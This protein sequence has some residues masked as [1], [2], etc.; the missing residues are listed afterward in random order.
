MRPNRLYR[1]ALTLILLLLLAETSAAQGGQAKSDSVGS[2]E[3]KIA[4]TVG[5]AADTPSDQ[6]HRASLTLVSLLSLAETAAAQ[7][8]QTRSDPA[9]SSEEKIV[10]TVRAADGPDREVYRVTLTLDSL[11]WLAETAA[12]QAEQTRSNPVDNGEGKIAVT[13]WAAAD[14]PA[15]PRL[16]QDFAAAGRRA[17]TLLRAWQGRIADTIRLHLPLC[18]PCIAADRDQAAEAVR[19]A[20]L[21]ASNDADRAALSQLLDL[22]ENFQ[23]WSDAL[24]EDNKTG[25][26]G[27]YYMSPTGLNDDPMF[28]KTADCARFLAPMLAS[29][30]LAEDA[31]C[32]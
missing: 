15:E 16:S 31:S 29:R 28:Q 30:H 23:R 24:V 21:L 25:G 14:T 10:V 19:L 11:L 7:A 2:N 9:D 13:A 8:G 18:E 5:A 32:Q 1:A 22:F 26:L 17:T 12:A 20:A 27:R 4:V 6:S 3:E